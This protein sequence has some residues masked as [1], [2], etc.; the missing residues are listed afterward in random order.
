MLLTNTLS[1]QIQLLYSRLCERQVKNIKIVPD[2][3][4]LDF[5]IFAQ[6]DSSENLCKNADGR[7]LAWIL[8]YSNRG[9]RK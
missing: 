5:I 4:G 6:L 1:N 8:L 7:I 3:Q 2:C 9:E